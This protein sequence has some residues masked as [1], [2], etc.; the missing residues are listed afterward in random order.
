M[1]CCCVGTLWAGGPS[2][3]AQTPSAFEL[4]ALSLSC[5]PVWPG[6]WHFLLPWCSGEHHPRVSELRP[7]P[8]RASSVSARSPVTTSS[9]VRAW[10]DPED[11]VIPSHCPQAEDRCSL[12]EQGEEVAF[13]Q[14]QKQYPD[15]KCP[16]RGCVGVS[17]RRSVWGRALSPF[18]QASWAPCCLGD[19]LPGER[20]ALAIV[21]N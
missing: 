17:P 9:V 5:Q 13:T 10:L 1:S 21:F 15:I 12:A 3:L 8:S 4:C 20:L 18:G 2:S 14:T 19:W 6:R 16:L 7:C 11:T